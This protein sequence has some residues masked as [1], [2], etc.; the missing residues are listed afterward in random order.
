M[1]ATGLTLAATLLLTALAPGTTVVHVATTLEG[2]AASLG[3][4]LYPRST[5]SLSLRGLVARIQPRE[6]ALFTCHHITPLWL[7]R[8]DYKNV[9]SSKK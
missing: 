4:L 1:C 8:D 7:R 6:P 5:L 3:L 2:I 9:R